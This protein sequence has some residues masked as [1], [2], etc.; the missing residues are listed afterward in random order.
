MIFIFDKGILNEPYSNPLNINN[1]HA[2]IRTINNPEE[3]N[4]ISTSRD[5]LKTI[6]DM[7]S[8]LYTICYSISRNR[9][10]PQLQA[11]YNIIRIN[12]KP[13]LTFNS[14]ETKRRI[15]E[16]IKKVKP[17]MGALKKGEML[18]DDTAGL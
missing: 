12:L 11:I 13:N 4:E 9:S 14:E 5:E 10:K 8:Q 1:E 15:Q 7:K 17:V 6:K 18:S 2:T 3:T 16:S